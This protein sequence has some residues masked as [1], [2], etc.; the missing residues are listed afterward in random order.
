MIT[1]WDVVSD[2]LEVTSGSEG[3]GAQGH[4]DP[5]VGGA[6]KSVSCQKR[7]FMFH[8]FIDHI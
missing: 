3:H 5:L 2:N 1:R 7:S 4:S 6:A 8:S